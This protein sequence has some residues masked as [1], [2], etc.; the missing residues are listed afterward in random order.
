MKN[1]EMTFNVGPWTVWPVEGRIENGAVQRQLQPKVM[2]VLSRL[3][4]DAGKVVLRDQLLADVWNGR[5]MSDEPLH[6]CVAALRAAL[7]DDSAR[8]RYIQTLPRRGYRLLHSVPQLFA[9]DG[10]DGSRWLEPGRFDDFASTPDDPALLFTPDGFAIRQ[11]RAIDLARHG[12][13]REAREELRWLADRQPSGANL[14][15]LASSEFV[16]GDVREARRLAKLAAG[17]GWKPADNLEYEIAIFCS[18]SA[19]ALHHAVPA[20]SITIKVSD[21]Q[22]RLLTLAI[23]DATC[24]GKAYEILD[25]LA[26]RSPLPPVML[27]RHLLLMGN[28]HAAI[29]IA[30]HADIRNPV[31]ACLFYY[32]WVPGR[33]SLREHPRFGELVERFG[34]T[35]FWRERG[36][37]DFGM[38][39]ETFG[40][41]G[42]PAG[43]GRD[44]CSRSS[45][46]A[47]LVG[48]REP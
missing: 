36:T 8:Q 44:S 48:T 5:A 11:R 20:L 22:A 41:R 16:N 4:R 27:Y 23:F 43:N 28:A 6:R 9:D 7:G 46:D 12:Y 32:L 24:R 29:D 33:F 19:R 47:V 42:H 37:N 30:L 13:L 1:E 18:D 45:V 25:E 31:N 34:L 17:M 2:A 26:A 38:T 15:W 39:A 21:E 40:H 3:A 10:V 14:G 35:A